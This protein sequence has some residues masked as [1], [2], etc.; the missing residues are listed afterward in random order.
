MQVL[1]K[2][3]LSAGPVE[4]ITFQRPAPD[5]IIATLTLLSGSTYR[6]V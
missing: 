2:K 6:S 3:I 4:S 5:S 1:A